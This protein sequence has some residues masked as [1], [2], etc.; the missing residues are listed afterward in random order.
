MVRRADNHV[1]VSNLDVAT[2][3]FHVDPDTPPLLGFQ[4]QSRWYAENLIEELD[5][6]EEYYIDF[7][8]GILFLSAS[9]DL[10]D[11]SVFS[12]CIGKFPVF[13]FFLS[14]LARVFRSL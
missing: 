1:R 5:T 12:Y 7:D 4:R 2:G 14:P 6:P 8:T 10:S 11:V 9:T 3:T 13:M